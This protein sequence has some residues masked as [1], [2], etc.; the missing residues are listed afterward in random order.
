MMALVNSLYVV[1]RD[2]E[3][4]HRIVE[5]LNFKLY[6]FILTISKWSGFNTPSVLTMLPKGPEEIKSEQDVYD[7]FNLTKEEIKLINEIV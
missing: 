7:Y 4:G 2:K 5:A 6:K 3:E 1:V